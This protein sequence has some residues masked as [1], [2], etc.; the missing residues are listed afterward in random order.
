[1]NHYLQAGATYQSFLRD[2]LNPEV[3]IQMQNSFRDLVQVFSISPV[4]FT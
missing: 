1:M 4:D 2:F 3:N